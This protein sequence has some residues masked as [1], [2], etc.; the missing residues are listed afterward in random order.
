M[1]VG[2]PVPLAITGNWKTLGLVWTGS[3]LGFAWVD[4]SFV[5]RFVRM[6]LAGNLLGT[7]LAL[8]PRYADAP[9]LAY[10]AGRWAVAWADSPSGRAADQQAHVSVVDAAGTSA[11]P[12]LPL[13]PQAGNAQV[14]RV[15]RVGSRWGI[16]W[17]GGTPLTLRMTLVSDDGARIEASVDI[18][19]DPFSFE[20]DVAW[21]GSELAAVWWP[22]STT[23]LSF[24]AFDAALSPLDAPTALADLGTTD[25]PLPTVVWDATGLVVA[26]YRW[27]TTP[28]FEVVLDVLGTDGQ[29]LASGPQIID[30]ESWTGSALF[31]GLRLVPT[32]TGVAAMWG[33]GDLAYAGHLVALCP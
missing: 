3:E 25:Q 23:T 2:S 17:S 8:G 24:A 33:A 27:T 28:G 21:T 31:G 13:E 4:D 10:H 5:A 6:D 15:L 12:A 18:D 1:P 22:G 14:L 26:Y 11:T 7:P 19:T 9:A 16:L 30:T 29:P 20:A 32:G